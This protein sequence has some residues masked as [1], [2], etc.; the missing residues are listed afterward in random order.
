M[1]AIERWHHD[2]TH[3][4][5]GVAIFLVCFKVEAKRYS[6]CTVKGHRRTHSLWAMC[7]EVNILFQG[8]IEF[9][10]IEQVGMRCYSKVV[11]NQLIDCRFYMMRQINI[12]VIYPE[13]MG[14]MFFYKATK[15]CRIP[16][17]LLEF[18]RVKN[19][20]YL[21]WQIQ[22]LQNPFVAFFITILMNAYHVGC[23]GL[24]GEL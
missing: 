18:R 2:F 1:K 17:V 22:I 23:Y 20:D 7:G 16:C 8:E 21:A 13:E 12:V 3:D 9:V 10:D 24:K 15:R 5:I 6:K 19:P 14:A 11:T 4:I